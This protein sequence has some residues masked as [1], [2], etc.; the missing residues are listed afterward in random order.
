VRP[1][2]SGPALARDQHAT[3][4]R[5]DDR[6]LFSQGPHRHR[7][8]DHRVTLGKLR[9][10]L[11]IRSLEVALTNR[12]LDRDDGSLETQWLLDKV[13]RSELCRL[14]R[15]LDVPV[16]G[17]HND[18]R[19]VPT[20]AKTLESFEPIDSLAE[21]DVEKDTRVTAL[22]DRRETRLA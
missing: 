16:T 3:I 22:L 13:E 7:F 10:H 21:P 2:L 6:D 18:R 15:R 1:T 19:I 20:L 12:V 8:A 5:C 4:G 9:Q 17:D 14:H 11:A